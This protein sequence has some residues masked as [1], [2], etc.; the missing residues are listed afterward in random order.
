M[1]TDALDIAIDMDP[2]ALCAAAPKPPKGKS[3]SSAQFKLQ[4]KQNAPKIVAAARRRSGVERR[5]V[6]ADEK[7]QKA[8]LHV[9]EGEKALLPL[10]RTYAQVVAACDGVCGPGAYNAAARRARR[11]TAPFADHLLRF[12]AVAKFLETDDAT[13]SE[14]DAM[15]RRWRRSTSSGRGCWR[16]TS[17]PWRLLWPCGRPMIVTRS[18]SS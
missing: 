5:A 12:A 2:K 13:W 8:R 11:A 15:E 6:Q 18:A 16:R 3:A 9:E 14:T 1:M 4:A 10:A 17:R 7:F